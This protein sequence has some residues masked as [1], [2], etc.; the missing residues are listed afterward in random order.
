MTE[1]AR[2]EPLPQIDKPLT[3]VRGIET[4]D[5]VRLEGI[6]RSAGN[7]NAEEIATAMELIDDALQTNNRGDYLVYVVENGEGVHGFV[8]VGPTP[9][10]KGVFDLYWIAVDTDTHRRGYGKALIKFAEQEVRRRGGRMVLIETSSLGSYQST[11]EFY[12]RSGYR[13]VARVPD[14]Y[15]A[16]DDKIIYSKTL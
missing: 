12:A 9:L 16:G 14:F 13:E 3:H 8:C 10:T 1:F 2:L 4:A 15:N 7:F 11:R 5:R 6:V